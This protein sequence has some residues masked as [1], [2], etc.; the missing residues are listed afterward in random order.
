MPTFLLHLITCGSLVVYS[1]VDEI[2][3]GN[4]HN[5]LQSLIRL[6]SMQCC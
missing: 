6:L 5:R 4:F 3:T 2:A 1:E